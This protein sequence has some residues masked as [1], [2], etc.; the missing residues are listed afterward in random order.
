MTH[1]PCPSSSSHRPRCYAAYRAYLSERER[2]KRL[3]F[4]YEANRTL[5]H[6]R[7]IA[8]ALEGLLLRSLDAFRAE[9]AEIILFGSDQNPSLRTLLGPGTFRELMEP[10]DS[11]VADE[12]RN[13][14]EADR[15]RRRHAQPALRSPSAPALPRGP[16]RDPRHGGAT[17]RGGARDR[18]DHAR[19]PL[20][21]RSLL[22]FTR[23]C[24][25]S[26]RWPPTPAWLCSTTAW[27]RRSSS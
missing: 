24:A 6:S 26:T 22:R 13:L 19:Q 9:M 25:C 23:T 7:E 10:V 11:E 21:R 15:H 27:S 4:L 1:A 12:M 14:L 20:R 3:E 17:P 8:H 2:H 16:R 5:V 18:R